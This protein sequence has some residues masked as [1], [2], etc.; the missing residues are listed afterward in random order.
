M[1]DQQSLHISALDLFRERRFAAAYGG[2]A[3]AGHVPSA[4]LALL[5][6]RHGADLFGTQ[7]SATVSRQIHWD[8]S[9]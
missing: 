1:T 8:I 5:M 7:W 3:D 9:A 2:F 6:Y 4:Q